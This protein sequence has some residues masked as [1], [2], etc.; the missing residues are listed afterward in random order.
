M[1]GVGDSDRAPPPG[2]NTD[3]LVDPVRTTWPAPYPTTTTYRPASSAGMQIHGGR[4][5]RT[6]VASRLALAM[7]WKMRFVRGAKKTCGRGV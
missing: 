7:R 4:L 1:Q 3:E 6:W 2:G 5:G